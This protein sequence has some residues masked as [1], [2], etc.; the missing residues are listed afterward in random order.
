MKCCR[1]CFADAHIASLLQT[2][3]EEKGKCDFCGKA[4]VALMDLRSANA[5]AFKTYLISIITVYHA[6]E[7]VSDM[8]GRFI[9][10]LLSEEL[11]VFVLSHSQ[12]M[13]F[14]KE[15]MGSEYD[16]Y[17]VYLNKPLILTSDKKNSVSFIG[18][19]TWEEFSEKLKKENRFHTKEFNAVIFKEIL[20][21]CKVSIDATTKLYRARIWTDDKGYE[22]EDMGAPPANKVPPGRINPSGMSY[23]YLSG[24]AQT[25]LRETRALI[26][27]R[28]TIGEFQLKSTDS[29]LEIIDL[30]KISSIESKR[31][32]NVDSFVVNKGLLRSLSQQ[33][34]KPQRRY[35]HSVEYIP[36]QYICD[37][38]KSLGYQ[39]I[40]YA[41]T[42]NRGG[43]NYAIFKPELFV[44]TGL[45]RKEIY[46]IHYKSRALNTSL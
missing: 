8:H 6:V 7:E 28:A 32:K 3:D 5:E 39:G 29:S 41:S 38:I 2:T 19:L 35:E 45:E 18:T 26:H 12:I 33:I 36:T 37:Y 31:F 27:D 30:T 24:D 22:I 4:N 21:S 1:Y 25:V 40:K 42:V 9:G 34:S 23:L 46:G 10:D 11:N 44:C 14:L 13:D 43:V 16:D 17:A 20:D 15:I